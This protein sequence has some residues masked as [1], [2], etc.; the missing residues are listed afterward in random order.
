MSILKVLGTLIIFLFVWSA[1]SLLLPLTTEY[2]VNKICFMNANQDTWISYWGTYFGAF[3]GGAFTITGV[4]LTIRIQQK[5]SKRSKINAYKLMVSQSR[6]HLTIDLFAHYQKISETTVNES[7]I[8]KT[9]PEYDSGYVVLFTPS[10]INV[11]NDNLKNLVVTVKLSGTKNELRN[12]NHYHNR[13][14]VNEKKK[15]NVEDAAYIL[16]KPVD[17]INIDIDV[18]YNYKDYMNNTFTCGA[19]FSMTID[20]IDKNGII[21]TNPMLIKTD[22]E[23]I[24]YNDMFII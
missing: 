16:V 4:Y 10:F 1:I 9:I 13:L 14:T 20:A 12:A 19:I 15:F 24:E 22:D 2:V 7:D 5:D 3:L 21:R 17:H 8:N 11:G 6:P 18:D 23:D